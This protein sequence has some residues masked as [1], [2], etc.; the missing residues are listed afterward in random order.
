MSRRVRDN[1]AWGL[2]GIG[3]V[4]YLI[5]VPTDAVTVQAAVVTSIVLF[6]VFVIVELGPRRRRPRRRRRGQCPACGYDLR[7]GMH[8][9]CPECGWRRSGVRSQESGV[10]RVGVRG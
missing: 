1:V 8:A 7:H 5:S 6:A 4:L 2:L 10:S 3:V 9:G